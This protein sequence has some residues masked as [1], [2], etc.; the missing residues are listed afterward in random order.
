V[1][2]FALNCYKQAIVLLKKDRIM[3]I[4]ENSLVY[5]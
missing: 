4:R 3:N 2:F 1:E 5:S